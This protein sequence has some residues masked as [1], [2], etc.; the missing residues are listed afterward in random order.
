M[1]G[2]FLRFSLGCFPLARVFEY[3]FVWILSGCLRVFFVL[4]W[5]VSLC[6]GFFEYGLVWILVLASSTHGTI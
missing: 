4:V 1:F 3:G 6:L 2:C 5:G